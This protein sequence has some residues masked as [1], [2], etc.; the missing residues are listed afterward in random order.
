MPAR[1]REAHAKD[2]EFHTPTPQ[3][4]LTLSMCKCKNGKG[5]TNSTNQL[6]VFLE[7]KSYI[8]SYS[9]FQL[10]QTENKRIPGTMRMSLVNQY[11]PCS[12][13]SYRLVGNSR[14][15]APLIKRHSLPF[16]RSPLFQT[17][18]KMQCSK[19]WPGPVAKIGNRKPVPC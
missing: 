3:K 15:K 14:G 7:G 12:Y 1:L 10:N 19:S 17:E 11:L 6:T 5:L 18:A 4:A 2:S 13:C 9:Y 16:S 8:Y